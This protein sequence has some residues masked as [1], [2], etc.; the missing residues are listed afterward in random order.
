MYPSS[1]IILQIQDT[2]RD[3]TYSLTSSVYAN[4]YHKTDTV[5][6][7]FADYM[8]L[9]SYNETF[10]QFNLTVKNLDSLSINGNTVPTKSL[11]KA[12]MIFYEDSTLVKS[13]RAPTFRNVG[14]TSILV[15]EATEN[16]IS[17]ELIKNAP[18]FSAIRSGSTFKINITSFV[19][20]LITSGEDERSLQLYAT[21]RGNDGFYANAL[22][23]G[24]N[25]SVY[26]PK[27]VLTYSE[28]ATK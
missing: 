15:F 5:L 10:M 26:N 23:F 4:Q 28:T 9:N 12:E 2:Q 21:L 24:T 20:Q 6:Y 14:A 27:I 22:L 25:S 19:N 3:T 8:S 7:P 11:S 18:R 17:D 13:L 16:S 1:G